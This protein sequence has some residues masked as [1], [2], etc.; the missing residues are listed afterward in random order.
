M[1]HVRNLRWSYIIAALGLAF[2]GCNVLLVRWPYV[3]QLTS[4]DEAA[5]TVLPLIFH[6]NILCTLV[7]GFYAYRRSS[8]SKY[9][10]AVGLI[11]SLCGIAQACHLFILF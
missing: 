5:N 2:I 11:C 4:R 10:E 7:I 9:L 1:K 6:F 3:L 8:G